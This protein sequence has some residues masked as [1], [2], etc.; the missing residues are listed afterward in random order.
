MRAFIAI[1]LPCAVKEYLGRFQNKLKTSASDIK[2]VNPENI[3]LTLKFLGEIEDKTTDEIKEILETVSCRRLA[4]YIRLSTLGAFP[5]INSPRIIWTGIDKGADETKEI[6][7]ELEERI[8][9]IGIPKEDKPFSAHLTIGRTRS[10]FNRENLAKTLVALQGEIIQD[11]IEFRADKLTLFKST[12]TPQG[13][14]YTI[15]KEAN[16]KIK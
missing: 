11:N 13:P 5:K 1:E 15:L 7:A 10:A 4:F 12:L 6:A 3:H 14:V 8:A 2:W 9:K 16:L